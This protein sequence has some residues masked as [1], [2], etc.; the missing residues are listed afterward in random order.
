MSKKFFSLLYLSLFLLV[1]TPGLAMKDA[2][3]EIRD[4]TLSARA[5]QDHHYELAQKKLEAF[6]EDYPRSEKFHE[7]LLLLGRS[8]LELGKVPQSI[9]AFS[10][11]TATGI[12]QAETEQALYW[13]GE[14][15]VRLRNFPRAIETYQRLI[16]L[17]ASQK[18]LPYA[19][20]SMAWSFQETGEFEKA[21]EGYAKLLGQFPDHPLGE[22]TRFRTLTC[23]LALRRLDP[24]GEELDRF[25]T[26]YPDS[27]WKAGALYVRGELLRLKGEMEETKTAY[28]QALSL[29]GPEETWRE[30]AQLN[31]AWTLF[32]L[33]DYE[34]ALDQFRK[35]AQTE[36]PFQESSLFGQALCEAGLE[37]FSQ[38]LDSLETLLSRFPKGIFAARASLEK[39]GLLYKLNR[40][41]EAAEAYQKVLAQTEEE[42][43]RVEAFYGLGWT[44]LR[45]GESEKAIE[46]FE[47]VVQ[48]AYEGTRRAQAL[49]HLGDIYQDKREI[50]KAI[51]TYRR[52]LQETPHALQADYAALQ[53]GIAHAKGRQFEEAIRA[54]EYFLAQFPESALRPEGEYQLG[55]AYFNLGQFNVARSHFEKVPAASNRMLSESSRF[56]VANSLYNLQQYASA[57]ALF[58]SLA[59]EAQPRIASL[60]QYQIGWC[61]YQMGERE[62]AV[63]AFRDSL[64]RYPDSEIAPEVH[65]W[66]AEYYIRFKEQEKAIAQLQDLVE[67]FQKSPLAEE[68]LFRW[69]SLL[70]EKG[71]TEAAEKLFDQLLTRYPNSSLKQQALLEKVTLLIGSGALKESRALVDQLLA[72][73][74]Q[75]SAGRLLA[76]R[77]AVLFKN[78]GHYSEAIDYFKKAQTGDEYEPNAQIQYEIGTCYEAM[79]DLERALLEYVKLSSTYPKSTYWVV[80]ADLRSAQIFE[81]LGRW[82]EAMH[83]YEKLASWDR[84]E[85]AGFARERLK[86]IRQQLAVH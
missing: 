53:I 33:K 38:S 39:G 45:G 77:L 86:E 80:R 81:K 17:P 2:E 22:E 12:L 61:L 15:Y 37:A 64:T 46:A 35:L 78:S 29:A 34:E 36:G 65:F 67:N 72:Q 83:S 23:L 82:K 27:K 48:R 55:L 69:A 10:Q 58:Q 21:M 51:E 6:L 75:T 9:Q 47:Q 73:G 7:V 18:V 19:C 50:Q 52:V 14:A 44:A 84:L 43:L 85:E 28:Q 32:H 3:D 42:S 8:Y 71:K 66:L 79:G 1:P 25:L 68:A 4:F 13:T 70:A 49:C 54:F 76:Q 56:Q 20:Y 11:L 74:P 16:G 63:G 62:K 31:L 5:F 57:L 30:T 40:I 41:A 60:S 59:K 26:A 24:L